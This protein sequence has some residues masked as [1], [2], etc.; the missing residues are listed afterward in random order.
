MGLFIE[1]LHA[2]SLI[3]IF[4]YSIRF[5]LAVSSFLDRHK[6]EVIELHVSLTPAMLTIQ[7]AIMDVMNACLKELKH[8]NPSLDVEDLSLENAVGKSFEKVCNLE[9]CFEEYI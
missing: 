5:H 4:L 7:T 8:Y 2:T 1:R 9:F 3:G 6:P